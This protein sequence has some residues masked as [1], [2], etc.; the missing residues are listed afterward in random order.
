MKTRLVSKAALL[1]LISVQPL[2]PTL[3]KEPQLEQLPASFVLQNITDTSVRLP[4]LE[5]TSEYTEIKITPEKKIICK[6]NTLCRLKKTLERDY[7][8]NIR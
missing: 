1:Q 4:I 2:L 3:K 6:L 5:S 8:F 7:S